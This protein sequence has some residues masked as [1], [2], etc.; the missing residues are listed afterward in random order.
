[1][2][3]ST[4]PYDPAAAQQAIDQRN[5]Y[6]Q[7]L[8][9]P[10][11][12]GTFQ[13]RP[14]AGAPSM[15][16]MMPTNFFGAPRMNANPF[17][18]RGGMRGPMQ[19]RFMPQ[20]LPSIG[21]APSTMPMNQYA[22]QYQSQLQPQLGMLGQQQQAMANQNPAFQQ[23]QEA[24]NQQMATQAQADPQIQALQNQ[25]MQQQYAQ[26]MALTGGARPAQMPFSTGALS[27]NPLAGSA[28]PL[29]GVAAMPQPNFMS[30]SG[31]LTGGARPPQIPQQMQGL[32]Y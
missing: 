16:P 31:T 5:A 2:K 17:D 21:G 8:G 1:M 7:S 24:M 27:A 25:A 26:S 29:G 10:S 28:V 32:L 22:S 30:P 4:S 20:V 11:Q 3:V 18:S 23:L 15:M 14:M 19:N 12:A 9:L 13:Q 6:G